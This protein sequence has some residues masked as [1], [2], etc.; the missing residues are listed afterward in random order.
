MKTY[1]IN[2]DRSPGRLAHMDA[3]L[4]RLGLSYERV[5]AF[6]GQSL[7]DGEMAEADPSMSRGEIGCFLS[8]CLVWQRIAS[9][10]DAY[11][12]VL[13]DDIHLAPDIVEF[14]SDW[15]WIPPGIDIVKLETMWKP[16]EI[17][18]ASLATRGKYRLARLRS[19]HP[20]AAGYIISARAAVALLEQMPK[21]HRPVDALLFEIADGAAQPSSIY[22]VD[23]ALCVQDSYSRSPSRLAALTSTIESERRSLRRR[24]TDPLSRIRREAWKFIQAVKN[25]RHKLATAA[26]RGLEFKRIP[27]AGE[28]PT[29]PIPGSGLR[30]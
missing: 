30:R 19:T 23:P 4:T 24:A 21:P 5:P 29:V 27:F 14:V 16:V 3:Q 17:E 18:T 28:L 2:L 10:P 22:Q 8:H 12:A 15:Q 11:A 13:E 1:L 7:T 20:G 25:R 6:D 9:R 26:E